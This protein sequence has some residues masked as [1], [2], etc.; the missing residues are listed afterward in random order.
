MQI[1]ISYNIEMFENN[2][3]V[4]LFKNN[5]SC[6]SLIGLMLEDCHKFDPNGKYK[7]VEHWN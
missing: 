3:W 2:E 5:V 4:L 1:S 7:I 6:K